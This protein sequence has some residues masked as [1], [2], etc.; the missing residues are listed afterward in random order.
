MI[1]LA[2]LRDRLRASLPQLT[3]ELVELT[4]A[5]TRESAPALTVTTEE[6][7]KDCVYKMTIAV[8]NDHV[9][10][11]VHVHGK[12]NDLTT[13]GA[14]QFRKKCSDVDEVFAIVHTCWTGGLPS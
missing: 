7:S 4:H 3:Y 14:Q 13:R 6:R 8:I 12:S 2:L 11:F 5:K 1:D 9:N 10:F